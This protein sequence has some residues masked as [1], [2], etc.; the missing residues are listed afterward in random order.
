MSRKIPFSSLSDQEL[1]EISKDL[2]IIPEPSKYA[3]FTQP[4]PIFLFEA[5]KDDLYVPFAYS[6]KFPV[7]ERDFFP[8]QE[9]TF[10]GTLRKP[11][12]EIQKEAITGLN[13][14]G[15]VVISA[16]PG[17]GKSITSLS[18]ACKIHMKTIIV[19]HRIQLI[20][21][22]EESI[23]K[24]CDNATCQVI[25]PKAKLLDVDFYIINATNVSKHNRD[26][27]KEIG[28][29]IVDE[30]HTI[31]AEKVSQCMRY[32]VPR[33][34]LGLS[35]T[36][37]RNDGLDI[38]IDMYFGRNKLVRKLW[39]RHTVYR[40]DTG[41]KPNVEYNKQGKVDWGSV[42][43]S[44]CN[45]EYRNE[46]IIRLLKL[47]PDNVFLVLC[48][49]VSQAEYLV[50]RLIEEKEDVTS[51]I[52][53]N[54]TYEQK[55][56]ILVGTTGKTSCGFD[57]PRLNAMILASDVQQYYVQCLG[58]TMRNEDTEPVIFDILDDHPIL[59]RHFQTRFE[60]YTEHGGVVK[61]FRN[62]FPKFKIE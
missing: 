18:I 62:S 59:K 22:W 32:F 7:P 60:V 38:L 56:R 2:Q 58:R 30:I 15:S 1:K 10:S 42:I 29:V 21:Q 57:H 11:Q 39:R 8:Q 53:K 20:K 54:Q 24:F 46:M 31:M 9:V 35:A 51:L 50:K 17:F 19:V 5:D 43:D 49:R 55:S 28:F 3:K 45:N 14:S 37:Y 52:G 4:R 47:F 26:F 13:K 6:T 48:K 23:Q 33:Y 34:V 44:T 16:Y 41:I 25:T 61:S 27:Y 12:K 36:P 40:V